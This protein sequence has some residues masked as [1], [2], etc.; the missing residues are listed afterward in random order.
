M[1]KKE[2]QAEVEKKHEED[3]KSGKLEKFNTFQEGK[4]KRIAEKLAMKMNL[5]FSDRKKLS[6]SERAY[7]KKI[8]EQERM[9]KEL[10]KAFDIIKTVD[11]DLFKADD[12]KNNLPKQLNMYKVA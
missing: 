4:E 9:I 10:N 6:K 1:A 3:K 5:N 2:K 7:L 11:E 8:D 12:D